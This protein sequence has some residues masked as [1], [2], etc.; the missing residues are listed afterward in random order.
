MY[1][2]VMNSYAFTPFMIQA[3]LVWFYCNFFARR[4]HMRFVCV[5]VFQK[6]PKTAL[7]ISTGRVSL[8]AQCMVQTFKHLCGS[9]PTALVPGRP[10]CVL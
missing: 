6:I 7:T 5:C 4:R 1:G 10:W 3:F 8:L 2:I 9:T